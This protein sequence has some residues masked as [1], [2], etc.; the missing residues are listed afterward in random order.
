MNI[1]ADTGGI[2]PPLDP[3]PMVELRLAT[4]WHTLC[5]GS[6]GIGRLEAT[7]IVRDRI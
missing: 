4:S 2:V 3:G 6:T 1:V 7:S 5:D